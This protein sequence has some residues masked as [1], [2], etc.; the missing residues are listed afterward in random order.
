M[1]QAT[2][3]LSAIALT[4]TLGFL[5]TPAEAYTLAGSSADWS[6]PESSRFSDIDQGTYGGYEAILWGGLFDKPH[7]KSGLGYKGKTDVDFELGEAFKVGHILHQNEQT[8]WWTEFKGV[9]LSL[10]LDFALPDFEETLNFDLTVDETFNLFWNRPDKVKIDPA[11]IST[12]V[13]ADGM[14]YQLDLWFGNVENVNGTLITKEGK[15]KKRG[16]W[17]KVQKVPEPATVLGLLSVGLFGISLKRKQ[18][19]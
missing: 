3:Q 11:S 6:N 4:A 7:E 10:T 5:A 8:P 14:K 16:V 13:E 17:A 1:H 18:E 15:S 12:M 19:C 2:A 9:D